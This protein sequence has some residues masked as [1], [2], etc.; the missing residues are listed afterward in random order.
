MTD[1]IGYVTGV[2]GAEMSV[3]LDCERPVAGRAESVSIGVMVKAGTRAGWAVGL[4]SAIRAEADGVRN[5][6]TVDLLGELTGEPGG[7]LRFGRGVSVHPRLGSPVAATTER[8]SDL[9]YGKPESFHARI[10]TVYQDESRPAFLITDD[11]LAKHFAIVGS[12]G[13]GKSCTVTLLLRAI[14]NGHPFAHILLLDP[15]DEY[16]AAFGDSAEVFNVD[17]LQLPCW[18]LNFEELIAVLV[19]GGSPEEQQAQA[20]IVK[21]AVTQARR[22]F[23]GDGLENAWITVDTPVP[24][25]PGDLIQII[26][27]T[28]GKLNKADTSAPYLRLKSR[29]RVPAFGQAL[30]VHVLGSSP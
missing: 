15:H 14:L 4:V 13:S 6:L 19:R 26:D 29:T 30:P 16:A 18:L 1:V 20:S 27:E 28:M 25:R 3:A 22:K 12:T 9:I 5:I 17:N 8:D 23:A 24:F 7:E 11:L 21:D 10:G 2:S